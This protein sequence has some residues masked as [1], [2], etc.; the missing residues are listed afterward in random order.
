MHRNLGRLR[1]RVVEARRRVA[2]PAIGTD[3]RDQPRY[4]L[5][6]DDTDGA[7]PVTTRRIRYGKSDAAASKVTGSH[8][9]PGLSPHHGLYWEITLPSSLFHP[10][11]S[12]DC[13]SCSESDDLP[14]NP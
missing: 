13:T 1:G 14:T 6:V 10:T 11:R 3:P 12:D 5:S 2:A 4:Y 9:S 8:R 7:T